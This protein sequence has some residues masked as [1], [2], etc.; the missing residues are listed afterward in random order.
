MAPLDTA[1]L[2]GR[3]QLINGNNAATPQ[4]N[5][6]GAR[7]LNVS[8]PRNR[9]NAGVIYSASGLFQQQQVLSPQQDDQSR[10]SITS[11]LTRLRSADSPANR[12]LNI[13]DSRQQQQPHQHP[14]PQQQPQQQQQFTRPAVRPVSSNLPNIASMQGYNPFNFARES[15]AQQ[16][17]PQ[18]N[19]EAVREHMGSE[20]LQQLRN[21]FL[22]SYA[23]VAPIMRFGSEDTVDDCI[24]DDEDID[25]DDHDGEGDIE[26]ST[27][28]VI[29][30]LRRRQVL[31]ARVMNAR[32]RLSAVRDAE[33]ASPHDQFRYKVVCKLQCKS[34]N[35]VLCQRGMKAILLADQKVEL[36]STDMPPVTN[37][38]TVY[39]DYC[40]EKCFCRVQDIAC[41]LCGNI[42]GYHVAQPCDSCLDAS[43]NGHFWMFHTGGVEAQERLDK[44]GRPL[45]WAFLPPSHMDPAVNG[46][47]RYNYSGQ[48]IH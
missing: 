20:A 42:V 28:N 11:L 26:P 8:T 18:S 19:A 1:S 14:H 24:E 32:Q 34:C 47:D 21:Y 12:V 10:Y 43:N 39:Q 15:T 5:A 33:L 6:Q 30:D 13:I 27:T 22:H 3:M 40:T 48:Q 23:D 46:H 38:G 41:L 37:V 16:V 36:Y 17:R 29:Q 7:E 31:Y 44:K 2:T 9:D 35:S 25:D 45:L 4:S